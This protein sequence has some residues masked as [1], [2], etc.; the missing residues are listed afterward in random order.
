MKILSIRLQNLN[1]LYGECLIDLAAREYAENGIFAIVGPT[2][3]GKS[4]LLDAVCLALYGET[5][6]VKN[7]G[8]EENEVM[9][10]HTG[11]C[12]AEVVFETRAGKFRAFWEHHRARNKPAGALQASSTQELSEAD[13]GKILAKNLRDCRRK[14]EELTGLDFKRFTRTVLLAQGN[15]T[16][17]LSAPEEERAVILEQITG[18]EIYTDVS[19]MVGERKKEE[20]AKLEKL[21]AE[22]GSIAVLDEAET[23]TLK[24]ARSELEIREK[25]QEETL[26]VL[27]SQFEWLSGV[28]RLESE[29]AAIRDETLRL[30][31]GLREFQP[32][33]QRLAAALRAA[34]FEGEYARLS[35][36]RRQQEKEKDMLEACRA[37]LSPLQ[38]K[39]SAAERSA[40]EASERL[41]QRKESRRIGLELLKKVRA[42]DLQIQAG[43]ARF[44]AAG[45]ELELLQKRRTA[46]AGALEE[47]ERRQAD[48]GK[49]HLALE[50]ELETTAGDEN[51]AGESGAFQAQLEQWKSLR[52]DARLQAS[53]EERL[54]KD[55][56]R[57]VREAEEKSGSLKQAGA[58]VS[59]T[60][61]EWKEAQEKYEVL[62]REKSLR[63]CRSEH[64]SLLRE[65]ACLQKIVSL[66][67]E[68]AR[69]TDGTPCPLCGSKEHPYAKEN[70]PQ[71]DEVE[72]KI[73]RLAARIREME[74]W[75]VRCA[76]LL[77]EWQKALNG[78]ADAGKQS[79]L[80][81]QKRSAAH[82]AW[83][84]RK[85]QREQAE[86]RAGALADTLRNTLA[87]FHIPASV[88]PEEALKLLAERSR[89]RVSLKERKT[90]L[91]MKQTAWAERLLSLTRERDEIAARTAEKEPVFQQEKEALS[92][93]WA[94]R[95][96]LFADRDP[97]A[98]EKTLETALSDAEEHVRKAEG[99]RT[100]LCRSLSETETRIAALADSMTRRKPELENAESLFERDRTAAG[101]SGEKQFLEAVLPA[102]ERA[103]LSAES[104]ALERKAAELEGRRKDRETVLASEKEKKRTD[105][106][107]GS[108]SARIA[109]TE[110][111]QKEI[112]E[113]LGA[114]NQKLSDNEKAA[115]ALKDRKEALEK[116]LREYARWNRLY[117]LIG[118]AEGKNYR[119]F[120]QGL[121]FGRLVFHA[122]RTLTE[123]SDRY[124]LHH[125]PDHALELQVRDHYQAGTVRTTKN[126]S[127]G[128]SFLVSLALALGLSRMA[129]RTTRIDTLFLD[130]GFGTLDEDALENALETLGSLRSD[131]KLIGVISHVAALQ[132]RIST[133]VKIT[134]VSAGRSRVS[135]PGVRHSTDS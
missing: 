81:E 98:E 43:A 72:R 36:L 59:K 3:A 116:Q 21:R 64:E 108:L 126:L 130:E 40:K 16:A 132:E 93:L 103:R 23:E 92:Q 83:S 2:G 86:S 46:N 76:A 107:S 102:P 122:N 69:L 7:F 5:P 101:F 44:E 134:P 45:K 17:F 65:R 1:S 90:E 41:E 78:A 119:N 127:G 131:G 22:C 68:R 62:S 104:E 87:G 47:L 115:A 4:T 77:A 48:A 106:D 15:F 113:K 73:A 112:R 18:T 50:K 34:E 58:L 129:G 60:E 29:L 38:E 20:S 114:A 80:A 54:R 49:K 75:E 82:A 133:Q 125:D 14:V 71:T 135:G 28:R 99:T 52:A 97:D 100:E 12:R 91:E 70:I 79:E 67:E 53:E 19:R 89:K 26:R 11:E 111:F 39:V 123:M 120:V 9:S 84:A 42:L 94:E 10:R 57:L 30:G 121:T 25:E 105:L 13:T 37:A 8:K 88:L 128:E 31:N 56:A 66:E 124:E 6:R 61:K 51:L 96:G 110:A 24:T 95:A 55:L 109:E 63:E 85:E 32:R 35:E 27:R 33:K 117:E 74:E 118:T